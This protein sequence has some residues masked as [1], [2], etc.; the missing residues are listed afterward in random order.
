MFRTTG[1]R[2]G[3]G[4]SLTNAGISAEAAADYALA[5]PYFEESAALFRDLGDDWALSLP[6]RHLGIVAS[7]QQD[8]ARAE[9]LYKESLALCRDFGE[10]WLISLCLEELAGVARWQGEY[11]RAVRLWG[12]GETLRGKIG[13]GLRSLYHAD[14]DRGVATAQA[15]MGERAFA[16]AWEKGTA[17]TPEEA[18]AY[19]L[20]EEPEPDE[21]TLPAGLT[22]QEAEVLRLVA[23]LTNAQVAERLYLSPPTVNAHLRTI[24]GK[25]GVN[26]RAAATRFAAGHDLL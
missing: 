20:G 18:V 13:A 8:Y 14:Y 11:P 5:N 24:Y 2:W 6:L 12:A 22:G 19:A 9:G 10:R 17:L 23:G 7:R 4:I 26:S 1:E 25:L 3:L 15:G 16:A 21:T